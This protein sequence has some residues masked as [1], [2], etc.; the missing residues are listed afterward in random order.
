M[1]S[2]M[3]TVH[4]PGR[5]DSPGARSRARRRLR[6]GASGGTPV[7]GVQGSGPRDCP[8]EGGSQANAR[9][10]LP[11]APSPC[12][13]P[14]A[15]DSSLAPVH[16][17]RLRR[18]R[19][20][21]RRALSATLAV[22]FVGTGAA[23]GAGVLACAHHQGEQ[24]GAGASHDSSAP[25]D[26]DAT[27]GAGASHAAHAPGA[28]ERADA[29]TEHATESGSESVA[30]DTPPADDASHGCDCGFHC[31]GAVSPEG[32]RT[33]LSGML[34]AP[35]PTPVGVT[36]LPESALPPP[37]V[38]LPHALPWPLAPPV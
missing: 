13:P 21:F 9:C 7:D 1:K 16:P 27:H 2:R 11:C 34:A 23:H 28:G 17:M 12:Y 3:Y 26:S 19:R 6:A 4:W 10:G 37:T 32:V 31:A 38:L 5:R 36:P 8:A 14:S 33:D 20:A 18:T 29:I 30:P 35:G 24:H 25:H 15:G 22:L